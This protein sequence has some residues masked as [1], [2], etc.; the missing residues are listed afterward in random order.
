MMPATYRQ[1]LTQ[2]GYIGLVIGIGAPALAGVLMLEFYEAMLSRNQFGQM[3]PSP[4]LVVAGLMIAALLGWVMVLV[5][6]EHYPVI[7]SG[8]QVPG[9]PRN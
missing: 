7:Y 3:P 5:G 9:E 6:R 8:H 2:I 4:M 1:R